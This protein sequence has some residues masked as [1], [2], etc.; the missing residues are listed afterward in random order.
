[1]EVYARSWRYATAECEA[2]SGKEAL[3][4]DESFLTYSQ[5]NRQA[6]QLATRLSPWM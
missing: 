4:M 1:M 6:N 3:I 2:V 5:L